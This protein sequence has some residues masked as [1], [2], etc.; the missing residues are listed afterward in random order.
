MHTKT[1]LVKKKFYPQPYFDE[2]L[3]YV[4]TYSLLFGT[5]GER[6]HSYT[7]TPICNEIELAML[8]LQ[9]I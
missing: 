6:N 3:K 9:H 5:V 1:K 8:I 4:W 7:F 2:Y